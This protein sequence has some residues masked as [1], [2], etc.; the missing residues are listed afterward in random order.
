MPWFPITVLLLFRPTLFFLF[1][2]CIN[3]NTTNNQ[4]QTS[5][6]VHV[7]EK[8]RGVKRM[9]QL[10]SPFSPRV[11]FSWHYSIASWPYL[12][13]NNYWK[14]MP[15]PHMRI[16][17]SH[18]EKLSAGWLLFIF[19]RGSWVCC[20]VL[21]AQSLEVLS[22]LSLPRLQEESRVGTSCA[23]QISGLRYNF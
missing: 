2:S 12:Q 7:G 9:A 18:G 4:N 21:R 14:N 13:I 19:T 17:H 20:R 16:F 10:Y 23:L 11:H 8:Q 22:L 15:G 5:S 1:V 3:L 6:S